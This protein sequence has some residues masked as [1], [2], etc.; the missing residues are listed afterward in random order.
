[1]PRSPEDFLG[2]IKDTP[3][4]IDQY[5]MPKIL[6]MA[7]YHVEAINSVNGL[8]AQEPEPDLEVLEKQ[9]NLE[10]ALKEL[11]EENEMLQQENKDQIEHFNS[12][13]TLR[14]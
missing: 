11:K 7:K 8:A 1:L 9:Q 6:T 2:K 13:I 3:D 4:I 14:N 5:F 10:K 12:Q